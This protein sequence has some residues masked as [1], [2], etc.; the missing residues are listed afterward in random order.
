[1]PGLKLD[2]GATHMA[3]YGRVVQSAGGWD[4]SFGVALDRVIHLTMQ[5]SLDAV[6]FSFIVLKDEGGHVA[7]PLFVLIN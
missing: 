4:R 3:Q 5:I 2:L 1:M 6:F 7:E